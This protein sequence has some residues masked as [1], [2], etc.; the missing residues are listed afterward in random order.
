MLVDLLRKQ[1]P[2][3]WLDAV[4]QLVSSSFR[5][6]IAQGGGI[7]LVLGRGVPSGSPNPNPISDQNL[8]FHCPHPFP[9]LGPIVRKPINGNPRLKVNRVFFISLD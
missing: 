8:P 7:L 6:R 1:T 3:R 9:D 5:T 2:D 4:F